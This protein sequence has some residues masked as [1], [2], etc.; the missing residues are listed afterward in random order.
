MRHLILG[1]SVASAF[2]QTFPPTAFTCRS[3]RNAGLKS[4]SE[5]V[6]DEA[7]LVESLFD[8]AN[9][10]KSSVDNDE[11]LSLDEQRADILLPTTGVSVSET[12]EEAQRDQFKTELVPVNTLPGVAQIVTKSTA[13]SF[14]PI[15][16]LVALSPPSTELNEEGQLIPAASNQAQHYVMTDIPPYSDRLAALIRRFMGPSGTLVAIIMTSRTGVHYDEGPS[17]YTTRVS[18]LRDWIAV[19]PD[20]KVVGYR[21]DIP[22]DCTQLVS[23]KLNGYGPW[24]WS[25]KDGAF[26]ETGRPL[27]TREWDAQAVKTM[28][29]KGILPP[30]DKDEA[31]VLDDDEY[32][33]EA[34]RKREEG[35]RLLAVYTPGH[36]H[37]TLS[38]VFPDV[39]VVVSGFTIPI[40]DPGSVNE[41]QY[42]APA[43]D[44]RGY[45]TTSGAGMTKQMESARRLVNTY[46]DRFG[47]VLPARD[48]PFFLDGLEEDE[49]K[50][51]MLRIIDQ[52][53]KIGQVYSQIGI[54][55]DDDDERSS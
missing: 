2:L 26:E 45:I 39:N 16:Y 8:A 3:S 30:E 38:Y 52:Y 1:V 21:L 4:N 32:T 54:F 15:R 47:I 22:R 31:T 12:M 50:N 11:K 25:D 14:D 42:V 9:R 33:P 10:Q 17:V 23:Q 48:D 6:P 35:K 49:R 46:G 55:S 28:L 51:I 34:I 24:A 7:K 27:I 37:G 5:L 13:G 19:F 36:T 40:E 41:G 20:L 18:C 44:V 43:M 53:D 29:R